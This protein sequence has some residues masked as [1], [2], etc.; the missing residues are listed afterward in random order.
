MKNVIYENDGFIGTKDNLWKYFKEEIKRQLDDNTIDFEELKNN[1][2]DIL[3]VMEKIQE[4]Q[5]IYGNTLLIIKESP[6]GS[7]YYKILEEVE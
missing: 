1:F 2:S 3:E 5:D 4:N 7:L 6:M